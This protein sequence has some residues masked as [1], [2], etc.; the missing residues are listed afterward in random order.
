MTPS[1]TEI[2][3]AAPTEAR[4]F[5]WTP[6]VVLAFVALWPTVGPAEMV[7]SLGAI[8][9]IAI[10]AFR[11]F[12]NGTALLSR[13][14]W[15]L[16]TV[17]FLCYWLPE[18]FSA[19]DSFDPS[20]SWR[21]VLLDLR[22]L[23]FLWL[24]AMAVA[25]RRDRRFVLAGVAI[26]AG[27]WTV[28]ACVQASTGWS[29]GGANVSDRLTG[30]FG[31][32]NQKLG[33]VLASLLPFVLAEADRRWRGAGW[34]A[35][36][37]LSGGVI[38]LAGSRASWLVFLLVILIAGWHRFGRRRLLLSLTGGLVLASA[39]AMS[40]SA[41][42]VGRIDRSM[43]ALSGNRAGLDV[44]LAG[45][46]SIWHAS[47][48]MIAAHPIN[49][50]GIRSFRDVYADYA[51]PDDFFLRQGEH[52]ALFA[53]QI[54]LEVLS[55]TGG[56]GLAFWLLGVALAQ[57]AWRWALAPARQRAMVAMQ[58]LLVTVFPLNT[59]LAFYSTFWGG[60]FLLLLA[61]FAGTLFAQDDDAAPAA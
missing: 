9:S 7:L 15:A 24:A 37:A 5:G 22:Y 57:R 42:F 2:T 50:V 34:V 51:A 32:G 40:F 29:L 17:L 35:A 20:R 54:V 14:A 10:L 18:F 21:E 58:A 31:A 61:L 49:G 8:A 46:L 25:R 39:L 52:G 30:I 4:G 23:P 3:L 44:A 12:R 41:Q 60:V 28:D 33:P 59:H 47:L 43:A 1:S 11:R 36:A 48:G 53:H 13:E 56:I 38:L 6:Y 27:L 45:R 55:E 26:I 19:F 16:I